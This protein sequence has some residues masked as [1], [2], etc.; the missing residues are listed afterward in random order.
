MYKRNFKRNFIH[1]CIRSELLYILYQYELGR[2]WTLYKNRDFLNFS[3]KMTLKIFFSTDS[4]PFPQNFVHEYIR[5][6]LLY[7]SYQ[8]ELGPPWTLYENRD[9]LNFSQKMTLKIVP[10]TSY[11]EHGTQFWSRHTIQHFLS[12]GKKIK[13]QLR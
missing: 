12:S 1:E 2:F 5:S 10:V 9:F 8:Y 11:I 4:Q 6:V 7:I 3:Q 13:F